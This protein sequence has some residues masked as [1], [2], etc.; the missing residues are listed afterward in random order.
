VFLLQLKLTKFKFEFVK[1]D[2]KHRKE[3]S[4]HR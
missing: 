4:E 3:R 1:S 2:L